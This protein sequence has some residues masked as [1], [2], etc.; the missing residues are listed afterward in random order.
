MEAKSN[1]WF[2]LS[3]IP[4]SANLSKRERSMITIA[5]STV[6]DMEW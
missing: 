2:K 6:F 4:L 3:T 1:H 5:P